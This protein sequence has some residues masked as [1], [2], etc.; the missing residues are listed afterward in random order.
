MKKVLLLLL[1]VMSV[2]F[3][4]VAQDKKTSN[5]AYCEIVGTSNF[6]GSKIK[7]EVDFGQD[8]KL[9]GQN[10][11]GKLLDEKGE[12]V[13]FNSMVDAMNYM[14]NLGWEFVQAYVMP[15]AGMSKENYYH[16]LLKKK[17]EK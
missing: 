2:S 17:L 5:Y 4:S 12:E 10:I 11:T 3:S 15:I 1:L 14:S 9:W 13:K 7:V 8:K 6:S 16:F